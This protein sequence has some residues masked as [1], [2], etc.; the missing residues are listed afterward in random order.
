MKHI[1]SALKR[2][3]VLVAM[4]AALV[5]VL[6]VKVVYAQTGQVEPPSIDQ[7]VS[8]AMQAFGVYAIAYLV[9]LLRVKFNI[10][11]GSV[12]VMVIVN[13][14]GLAVSWLQSYLAIPGHSWILS[15]FAT[16]GAVFLSQAQ[17]QLN[18]KTGAEQ[19]KFGG[20][21]Q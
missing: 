15:M 7:I 11:P 20:A 10:I 6:A 9:N 12:F 4:F 13:V 14:I 18:G 2:S 1:V 8:G 3:L 16:F 5:C 19:Y 17:A 21:T